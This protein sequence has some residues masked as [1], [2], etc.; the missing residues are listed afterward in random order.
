LYSYGINKLEFET[1]EEA[2]EVSRQIQECLKKIVITLISK[3]AE[4]LEASILYY[5]DDLSEVMDHVDIIVNKAQE[6]LKE[7][8]NV[9]LTL[10]PPKIN[11][12]ESSEFKPVTVSKFAP[13][14]HIRLYNYILRK[15]NLND[16]IIKKS[17]YYIELQNYVKTANDLIKDEVE[18]LEKEYINFF[19]E[20]FQEKINQ[21]FEA[22]KGY[23]FNYYTI[24]EQAIKNKS[25]SAEKYKEL[26]QVLDEFIRQSKELIERTEKLLIPTNQLL[27]Q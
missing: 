22:L 8:F 6:R 20:G 17:G 16:L 15:L 25:L 18:N 10:E 2:I 4:S 11:I 1:E 3:L 23:L 7:K 24:L 9:S 27:E 26:R 19:K 5:Q 21:Y 12:C 14:M 13:K